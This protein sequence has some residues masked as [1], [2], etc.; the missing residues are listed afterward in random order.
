MAEDGKVVYKIEGDN[1]QAMK[2]L[3]EFEKEAKKT[4]DQFEDTVEDT[5][6]GA[7]S[8]VSTTAAKIAKAIGSA[9]VVKQVI[10]FGKAAV[11]VASD[12]N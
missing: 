7:E 4:G 1:S 9:F 3:D 5:M 6:N 11:G 2:A 8:T 12:L 10:E